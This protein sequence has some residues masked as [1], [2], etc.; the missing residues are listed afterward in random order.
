MK[1]PL[2]NLVVITA[3]VWIL[4]EL[5]KSFEENK[6]NEKPYEPIK[7]EIFTQEMTIAEIVNWFDKHSDD[8]DQDS[9]R[10]ISTVNEKTMKMFAFANIPNEMKNEKNMLL[11]IVDK[12]L[13]HP[14]VYCIVNF[15]TLGEDVKEL[16]GDEEYIILEE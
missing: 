1:H 12:A 13:C 4:T 16:M 6:T 11:S 7:E 14:K 10:F 2:L 5:L 8:F 3:S 15:S 9:M